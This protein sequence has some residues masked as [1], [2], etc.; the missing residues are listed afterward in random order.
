MAFSKAEGIGSRAKPAKATCLSRLVSPT[1]STLSSVR[2]QLH[3]LTWYCGSS[4][5]TIELLRTDDHKTLQNILSPFLCPLC[6]SCMCV[7][8][9]CN[10]DWT[11]TSGFPASTCW[12]VELQTCITIPGL[13]MLCVYASQALCQLSWSPFK[14]PYYLLLNF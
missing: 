13:S 9:L 8:V 1:I 14:F 2:T 4:Q 12:V 5:A 11:K 3:W 10:P 6:L 7:C